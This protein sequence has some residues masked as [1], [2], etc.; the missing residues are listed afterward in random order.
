MPKH[1]GP[2]HLKDK[3]VRR[4]KRRAEPG[5]GGG[6]GRHPFAGQET[7]GV[8]NEK[9][10]G[11]GSPENFVVSQDICWIGELRLNRGLNSSLV[12]VISVS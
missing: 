5:C 2:R 4:K 6:E 10:R 9:K 1:K 12:A 8:R 3:R 11:A 7:G